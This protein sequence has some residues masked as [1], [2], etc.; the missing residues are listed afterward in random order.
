MYAC[1]LRITSFFFIHPNSIQCA[2]LYAVCSVDD[3]RVEL[4]ELSANVNSLTKQL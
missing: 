2:A 3:Y 4:T 1:N